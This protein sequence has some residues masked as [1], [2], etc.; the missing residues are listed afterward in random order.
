MLRPITYFVQDEIGDFIA[1]L[2][3]G[4]RQ[5][6][7]HNPPLT[8]YPWVQTEEGRAG[9]IGE[10]LDCIF[11]DSFE[12]PEHFVQTHKTPIF[13][14]ETVP[15]GLKRNHRTKAGIWAKINVVEG[16]LR[17]YVDGRQLTFELSPERIGIVV[18]ELVHHVELMGEDVRFYV[19]FYQ[20]EERGDD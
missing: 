2:S 13:S 12:I 7:R 20:A 4:H 18:P 10:K 1:Y 17:Y 5:H 8:D 19:A 3:C 11:C 14:A 9:K 15:A 16:R 6:V